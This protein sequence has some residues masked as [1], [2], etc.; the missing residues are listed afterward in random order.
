[1]GADDVGRQRGFGNESQYWAGCDQVGVVLLGVGRDQNHPTG[2]QAGFSEKS[3]SEVKAALSTE[4]DAQQGDVRPQL[5]GLLEG[6]STGRRDA[7]DHDPL[8]FQ[9]AAGGV[10]E[11]RLSSTMRQ[12]SVAA[13][14]AELTDRPV[15]TAPNK[16]A[17]RGSLD[18]IVAGPLPAVRVN[19]ADITLP[20]VSLRASSS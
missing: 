20:F 9:Q 2:C 8:A 6:L 3:P 14:L 7:D 1:M 18:A 10:Q 16:Y 15:V 17:A 11:A 5:D 13:Q 12:R 4:V 19:V